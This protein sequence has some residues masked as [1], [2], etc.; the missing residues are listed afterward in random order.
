LAIEPVLSVVHLVDA[1]DG[2][3]QG[4]LAGAV[5]TDERGDPAGM[6]VEVH[7]GERLHGAEALVH[8]AQLQQGRAVSHAASLREGPGGRPDAGRPPGGAT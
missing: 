3:D 7:I 8:P 2:L 4:R 6:G 1:G 5:V